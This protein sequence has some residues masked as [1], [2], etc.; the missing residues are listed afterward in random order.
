MKFYCPLKFLATSGKQGAS[1][2]DD[3]DSFISSDKN[4]SIIPVPCSIPPETM[5]KPASKK[6]MTAVI[7]C[8]DPFEGLCTHDVVSKAETLTPLFYLFVMP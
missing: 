5:V 2:N 3:I 6:R 8:D 1:F 4:K 7:A